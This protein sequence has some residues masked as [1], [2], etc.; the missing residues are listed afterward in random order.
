MSSTGLGIL[1]PAAAAVHWPHVFHGKSYSWRKVGRL[2]K[3]QPDSRE[4]IFGGHFCSPEQTEHAV[5]LGVPKEIKRDE[6][7]VSMLPVGVEELTRA[8]HT[9]LVQRG[10]GIGSGLHDELYEQ[11]GARF[12]DTAAEIFAQAELIVKVKE[13]QPSEIPLLRAGRRF[14]PISISPPTAN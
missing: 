3:C 8:G 10:A 14:S 7:R 2:L 11:A 4:G 6:Y 13:P 12:E 5:I 9:V 1:P